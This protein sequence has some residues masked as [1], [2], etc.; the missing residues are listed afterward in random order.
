MMLFAS[1]ERFSVL[2]MRDFFLLSFAAVYLNVLHIKQRFIKRLN[3]F[4]LDTRPIFLFFFIC[5]VYDIPVCV[6]FLYIVFSV[7]LKLLGCAVLG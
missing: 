7:G 2:R 3:V 6:F 1:V 5:H 4:G